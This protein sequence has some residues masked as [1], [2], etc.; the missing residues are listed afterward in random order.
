MAVDNALQYSCQVQTM[1]KLACHTQNFIMFPSTQLY[2]HIVD[3]NL[4]PNC[5]VQHADIQVA[6]CIYSTNL[7]LLKGKTVCALGKL[8][9][10]TCNPAPKIIMQHCTSI[11]LSI[12]IMYV[13][14]I[15]FLVTTSHTLW[16]GTIESIPN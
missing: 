15:A 6:D 4:L 10:P 14:C 11:I 5:L 16:F 13:N 2:Q 8:I 3:H 9:D 1:A 7:G 12:D